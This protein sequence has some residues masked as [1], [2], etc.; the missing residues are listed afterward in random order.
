MFVSRQAIAWSEQETKMKAAFI[1]AV[2]GLALIAIGTGV[3]AASARE[4]DVPAARP[5]HYEQHAWE[6][7][8]GHFGHRHRYFRSDYHPRFDRHRHDRGGMDRDRSHRGHG[9]G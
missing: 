5:V 4:R 7:H 6:R 3:G 2:F 1:K 8:H 9:R